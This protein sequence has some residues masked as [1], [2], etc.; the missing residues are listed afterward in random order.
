MENKLTVLTIIILFLV[1]LALI[2]NNI[3]VDKLRKQLAQGTSSLPD[4]KYFELK[5]RIQFLM[6]SFAA[7][8]FVA[9]LLGLSSIT[10]IQNDV[11]KELNEITGNHT[12]RMDT[13]IDVRVDQAAKQIDT[14]YFNLLNDSETVNATIKNYLTEVKNL[15]NK[16]GYNNMFIV[17]E[18]VIETKKSKQKISFKGIGFRNFKTIPAVFIQ[19]KSN[20][21]IR[22]IGV[23]KESFEI[24]IE[25]NDGKEIKVSLMIFN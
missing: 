20:S 11:Y 4:E 6:F 14:A 18:L 13:L 16:V 8:V 10:E 25:E 21:K 3:S 5:F 22:L 2:W 17:N 9:G 15:N 12:K 23:T 24:L 19:P 7:I 1:M